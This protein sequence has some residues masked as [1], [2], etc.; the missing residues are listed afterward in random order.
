MLTYEWFDIA[1]MK[2]YERARNVVDIDFVIMINDS[3]L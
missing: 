2:F 3:D 1:R